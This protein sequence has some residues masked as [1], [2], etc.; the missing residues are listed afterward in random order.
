MSPEARIASQAHKRATKMNGAD[1][2]E[3]TWTVQPAEGRA[4]M[5]GISFVKRAELRRRGLPM[6]ILKTVRFAKFRHE[7]LVSKLS[8]NP[9]LTSLHSDRGSLRE[10]LPNTTVGSRRYGFSGI[11]FRWFLRMKPLWLGPM[12]MCAQSPSN[13]SI[14]TRSPFLNTVTNLE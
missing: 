4:K 7:M 2:D 5:M 8:S 11:M 6:I 13:R 12:I 9:V 1:W 10:G 3:A 14:S